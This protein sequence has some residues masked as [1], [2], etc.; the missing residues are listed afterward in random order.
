VKL[1]ENVD[2]P[3]TLSKPHNSRNVEPVFSRF[4]SCVVVVILKK[5]FART[6]RTKG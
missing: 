2:L 4:I 3:G 1:R 5:H 6:F